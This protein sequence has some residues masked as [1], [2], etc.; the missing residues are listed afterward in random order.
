MLSST[1]TCPC[2]ISNS[3]L[4]IPSTN[5]SH[6]MSM[7][8]PQASNM[9]PKSMIVELHIQGWNKVYVEPTRGYPLFTTDEAFMV[10]PKF[11]C[12][13]KVPPFV[14]VSKVTCG[15][16]VTR[17]LD[18][19]PFSHALAGYLRPFIVDALVEFAKTGLVGFKVVFD[20][21]VVKIDLANYHECDYYRR[22]GFV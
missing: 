5:F 6:T 19:M 22:R 2:P 13:F 17:E 18:K 16:H 4:K 3:T 12:H 7:A 21:K 15:P 9:E 8:T 20:V 10:S 14:S 11:T 1:H